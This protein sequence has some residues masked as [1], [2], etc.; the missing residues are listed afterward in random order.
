[1]DLSRLPCLRDS[2]RHRHAEGHQLLWDLSSDSF[3]SCF[4][5]SPSSPKIFLNTPQSQ[6]QYSCRIHLKLNVY[7]KI[8]LMFLYRTP[9]PVNC[10]RPCALGCNTHSRIRQR[11]GWSDIQNA[12]GSTDPGVVQ[13]LV[14]SFLFWVNKFRSINQIQNAFH[15]KPIHGSSGS[16]KE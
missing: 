12:I 3:A 14:D 9:L 4:V 6:Q 2:S 7:H 11:I 10:I 15:G 8:P 5:P 16:E 13:V 1:M